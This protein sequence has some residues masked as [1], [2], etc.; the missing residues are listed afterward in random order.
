[1]RKL[2]TIDLKDYDESHPRSKR[3]SA[4]AIIIKNKLLAM[5]Y[6]EKYKYYK[7]AG[8]GIEK[9]ENPVAALIRE[10][11]EETGL[12]VI[13]GTVKEYGE[14]AIIRKSD[15][16]DNT[17]F[18]QDNFYY[19]CDVAEGKENQKLDDYELESGFTLR[20]VSADEA[21]RRNR[22]ESTTDDVYMIER[23]SRV[24]EILKGEFDL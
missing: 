2:F 18:R 3:T 22:E 14:V 12:A 9:G 19:L 21:I 5:V 1:M 6:S 4:R 13:P 15:I 8:G 16:L 17:I 7:F 23:E 10:V 24:L 11:R 20:Y